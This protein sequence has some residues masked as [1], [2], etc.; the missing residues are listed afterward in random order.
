M[1]LL[2]ILTDAAADPW[3]YLPLLFVFSAAATVA[4]P[5]PVEIGL[6]N[7][8]IPPL[9]LIVVLG[10]GKA[11]GALLVLP[12]GAWVGGRI[13]REL[14]RY[15]RFAVIFARLRHWIAHWG[16]LALFAILSIPFMSDTAPIY[17]FSTMTGAAP[18]PAAPSV[19]SAGSNRPRATPMRRGP[20]VLVSFVA[21]MV[22][23]S[24]FLAIPVL[25]GW[26]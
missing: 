6:L 25:L 26:P 21:G 8:L 5:V 2:T 9:P 20:F 23:G 1:D 19:T 18:D 14:A 3:V 24:L 10:L 22:R 16:Y 13:E 12:L 17:A 11:V 7:P 4:L 15:P